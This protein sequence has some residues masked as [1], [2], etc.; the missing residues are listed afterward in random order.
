MNIFTPEKIIF[1]VLKSKLEG[2]GITNIMLV[3][4][5][6]TDRYNIMLSKQD[7]TSMK[8]EIEEN[9][10]SM[11]KKMFISKI[12]KKYKEKHNSEIVSI[13]LQINIVSDE[14]KVFI[15]DIKKEVQLFNY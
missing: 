1:R 5:V 12:E 14:M 2:T 3:F 15:E 7:N 11:L 6:K 4:N 10:I 9:E 8:L 13:I